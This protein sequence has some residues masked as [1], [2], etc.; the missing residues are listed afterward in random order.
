MKIHPCKSFTFLTAVLFM[1]TTTSCTK[2]HDEKPGQVDPGSNT[3]T[4]QG[5]LVVTVST[6]AGKLGD[7]GNAEDGNG[8]NARLWNPTKMVY[9]NRNN[10]LYV[11]DG[12]VIRSIDR[13]NNVKTYMPLGTISGFNEI[14]DIDLAPGPLGGT[15]YFVSKENDV[16]KVEP[17]GNTCK[18]TAI[19]NRIYGGNATGPL[20]GGDHFDGASG[21]ATGKNGEI[22]FFNSFWNTLRRI[23]LSGTSPVAGMVEPFAGKPLAT[24]SGNAWPFQDGMGETATFAGTVPDI[25]SDGNGNIYIADFRNDLV[26]M[27]TPAGKVTS[28]F[29]YKEGW[30]IDKDGPVSIAQ[31]NRVTQ[32]TVVPDGSAVF[33]STYGAGGN[34][35]P[36][37]RLLRPGKDVTT[38]A[39]FVSKYGDGPGEAA[40]FGT[41]GGLAATADGKTMWVSEPGNK[42]IRKVSIQ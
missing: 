2:P 41:I 35:L 5:K 28:L 29:Q 3:E 13:Q 42:V 22:Y 31:A 25:A 14:Q 18:A 33:F 4:G 11:A 8:I 27:V 39:G 34:N 12:T 16:W 9:D 32:V 19:S 7:H 1:F 17:D 24:R 23:T 38:L 40:G 26:R 21:V 37:L 10:M 15:L 6:I 36:A 20:N 30:G